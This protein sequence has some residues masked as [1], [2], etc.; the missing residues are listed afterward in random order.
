MKIVF[1]L[2]ATTALTAQTFTLTQDAKLAFLSD[3]YGNEAF[4]PNLTVK[5]QV[6]DFKNALGE[7][8]IG[9]KAEWADLSSG[10]YLRYGV[11]AGH[12]VD[13]EPFKVTPLVGYGIL[14][15]DGFTF[16]SFE[17]GGETSVRLTDHFWIVGL[18]TYTQRPEWQIWRYSF[19][20]GIQ[21]KL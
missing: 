9:L 18:H 10:N 2:L 12:S 15:R 6:H 14:T 3:D 21:Y 19:H 13:L 1:L 11:E 8:T 20:L 4:T 16:Q 17:L 7:L 5:A